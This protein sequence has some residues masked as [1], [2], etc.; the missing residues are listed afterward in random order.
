[1]TETTPTGIYGLD[2]MVSGGF[3]KKRIILRGL[4]LRYIGDENGWVK[5]ME[6]MKMKLGEPDDS[7]RRRPVPHD[8]RSVAS[9]TATTGR[10]R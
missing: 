9:G 1:M 8:P 3:P 6:F 4:P 5:E 10:T 2:E 7:G